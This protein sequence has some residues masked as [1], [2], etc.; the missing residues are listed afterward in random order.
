MSEAVRLLVV[1]RLG[2]WFAFQDDRNHPAPLD[3]L[4]PNRVLSW[5]PH[6]G[7]L[8]SIARGRPEHALPGVSLNGRA[9][10]GLAPRG[11]RAAVIVARLRLKHGTRENELQDANA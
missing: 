9:N 4:I 8:L 5:R 3:V 6:L 11:S 2:R 10:E 1:L 7:S